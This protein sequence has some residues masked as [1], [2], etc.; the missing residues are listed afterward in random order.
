MEAG[1]ADGRGRRGS[2]RKVIYLLASLAAVVLA[3]GAGWKP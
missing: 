3:V 2:M 1:V